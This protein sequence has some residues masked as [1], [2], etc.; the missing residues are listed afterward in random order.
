MH[1]E[2]RKIFLLSSL[3]LLLLIT[4]AGC[5]FW[6]KKGYDYYT[7]EAR[8]PQNMLQYLGQARNLHFQNLDSLASFV[9]LHREFEVFDDEIRRYKIDQKHMVDFAQ[10]YD[11]DTVAFSRLLSAMNSKDDWEVLHLFFVLSNLDSIRPAQK[12]KDIIK[13][14]H[15]NRKDNFIEAL[16]IR[17]K[18][19][20]YNI[21]HGISRNRDERTKKKII[22]PTER[23][24]HFSSEKVES[25]LAKGIDNNTLQNFD[26]TQYILSD[27]LRNGDIKQYCRAREIIID[28]LPLFDSSELLGRVYNLRF[29]LAYPY[30]Y[31]T[32]NEISSVQEVLYAIK[33]EF[34]GANAILLES[35]IDSSIVQTICGNVFVAD[36]RYSL[37][38]YA[39]LNGILGCRSLR[40][41]IYEDYANVNVGYFGVVP[42]WKERWFYF[43]ENKI[44]EQIRFSG[45]GGGSSTSFHLQRVEGAW[46]KVGSIIQMFYD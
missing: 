31:D 28:I 13:V 14:S 3:F 19:N 41:S 32:I 27:I 33:N 4:F 24:L 42:D 30:P 20:A 9:E 8:L 17:S 37:E 11:G 35:K 29:L 22:E 12:L 6:A 43:S 40:L 25:L 38:M 16:R 46:K 5:A 10:A 39:N 2:K 1:K 23:K 45:G 7:A 44:I 34:S 21:E 18:Q 36:N 15:V 26:S